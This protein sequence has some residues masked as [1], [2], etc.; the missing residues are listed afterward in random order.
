MATLT[1]ADLDNGRRDLQTVDA[2][3]NSPADFTQTRFGDSVLTLAGA[4]SRLGYQAPVPYA[5]GLDVD[6][7]LF[8]VSRDGVI[9]APDPSLV[10][11]T[12][13]AW[14]AAQWRPV[15][16]TANTSQIYQF[17]TLGAAEAAA[18][19]LP[20]G[21]AIIVE[22]VSQGHVAGGSYSPDSGLAA[23]TLTS[24]SELISYAGRS[25]TVDLV[26]PAVAAR[27]A[28]YGGRFNIRPAA[29]GVVSDGGTVFVLADGRIAEREPSGSICVDWFTDSYSITDYTPVFQKAIKSVGKKDAFNGVDP[30]ARISCLTDKTYPISGTVLLPSF[31]ELALN[32]ALLQGGGNNTAFQSAFYNSSGDLV[33]NADE[34]N[35]TQFVV[36]SG[37]FD[38]QF[39]NFN[40]AFDLFNFCE[41]S[42]IH[43][44]RFIG[45]NQA[46]RA[47]RCFYGSFTRNHSRSPLDPLALPCFDFDDEVNAVRLESNF[48]VGYNVGWKFS[49]KKDNVLLVNCGAESCPTGIAIHGNTSVFKVISGYFE[50]NYNAIDFKSDGNHDGVSVEGSWFHSVVN[51]VQGSTVTNSRWASDNRLNGAKL[52]IGT[53]FSPRWVVDI[54]TS[55]ATSISGTLSSDY[56]IG[57]ASEANQIQQAYSTVDGLI[58]IKALVTSGVAPLRYSGDPGDP[59]TGQ[60]PGCV[61]TAFSGYLVVDTKIRYRDSAVVAASLYAASGSSRCTALCIGPDVMRVGGTAGTSIELVNNNGY[62]RLFFRGLTGTPDLNLARGVVRLL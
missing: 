5:S 39:L 8:T 33:S 36:S 12:T 34:P 47:R 28:A 3:A 37:V 1:I 62:V 16:N 17:P 55:V 23:V 56:D 25:R 54:P 19:T 59:V 32:G 21:S 30:A 22:G 35:E 38:G 58:K 48:A 44:N 50:N 13:G 11:F 57:D 24:F 60:F 40:R 14:D 46:I 10:P 4:L 2:V 31:I 29:P 45:C 7:G 43:S 51:A 18:P 26:A 42:R 15:Q 41:N 20:T 6:T 9:Y 52:A 53:Q 49:G 27:P 61:A